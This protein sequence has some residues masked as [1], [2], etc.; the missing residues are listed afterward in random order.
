MHH[1]IFLN[2]LGI[3]IQHTR[4]NRDP[5]VHC[6]TCDCGKHTYVKSKAFIVSTF[7]VV[8]HFESETA[9]NYR[10]LQQAVEK[11]LFF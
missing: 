1:V 6:V 2:Y 11:N 9:K 5:P 3:R 7:C 10:Y 4:I 8:S